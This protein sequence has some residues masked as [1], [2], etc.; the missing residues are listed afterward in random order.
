MSV[1]DSGNGRLAPRV[2]RVRNHCLAVLSARRGLPLPSDDDLAAIEDSV[3][4]SDAWTRWQQSHASPTKAGGVA[5][6][7]PSSMRRR[8]RTSLAVKAATLVLTGIL[9][10]A[11][12]ERW[13]PNADAQASAGSIA[14]PW[15][16]V[17]PA[18]GTIGAKL[19]AAFASEV[20]PRVQLSPAEVASLVLGS[21]RRALVPMSSVEAR[22]DSLLWIRGR[23]RGQTMF[24]L[25]G[26]VRV[27]RRGVAELRVSRLVVD[28]RDADP[29]SVARLLTGSQSDVV[30]A[31]LRFDVPWF[32]AGFRPDGST[33][34]VI[35]VTILQGTGSR[36]SP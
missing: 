1:S 35:G 36:V 10:F 32:I 4:L 33:V 7:L 19:R 26:D 31:R 13:L 15:E 27:V 16:P 22:S 25:A 21:R 14:S 29:A 6:R 34:E 5:A 24:E 30:G 12:G 11:V 2:V 20:R 23:L 8:W 17:E 9:G 28:G 3:G 18:R